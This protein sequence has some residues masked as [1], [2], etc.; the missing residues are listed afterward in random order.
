MSEKLKNNSLK[1]TEPKN[2]V[3]E[4]LSNLLQQDERDLPKFS[5]YR[6]LMKLSHELNLSL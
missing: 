3:V 2:R 1:G 6:H 4:R 5:E